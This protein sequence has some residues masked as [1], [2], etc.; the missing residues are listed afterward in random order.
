MPGGVGG[1]SGGVWKVLRKGE[2]PVKG[3]RRK[4]RIGGRLVAGE[5]GGHAACPED[6]VG[7]G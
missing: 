3:K 2:E 5:D 7:D 6:V 4:R 1:L